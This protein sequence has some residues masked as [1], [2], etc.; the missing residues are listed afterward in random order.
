MNLITHRPAP[1]KRGKGAAASWHSGDKRELWFDVEH[2][3]WVKW[4]KIRLNIIYGIA[5]RT[6]HLFWPLMEK[7]VLF[8]Q[9]GWG[10]NRFVMS[11][12]EGFLLLA[13][14]NTGKE[15]N[16]VMTLSSFSCTLWEKVSFWLTS[17]P[18]P[19]LLYQNKQ[20]LARRWLMNASFILESQ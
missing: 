13:G 6:G 18:N 1:G 5:N 8:L 9:G 14:E 16:M 4:D 19:L 2:T 3:Q 17:S 7:D 20:F 15:V 12:R 11:S 10:W